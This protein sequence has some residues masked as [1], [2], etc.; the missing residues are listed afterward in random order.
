MSDLLLIFALGFLGSFGHCISMC[1]PLTVAFS[2]TATHQDSASNP[3]LRREPPG[4]Q[5]RWHH[6]RFHLVLNVGRL[7][8]YTLVGMLL[9]MIGAMVV[10]SGQ[11]A[12]VGSDFRRAIAIVTGILLIWFGVR[13]TYPKLLPKI[14]L[15]LIAQT[16]IHHQIDRWMKGLSTGQVS[17]RTWVPAVLG[18]VWGLMP[19]GFLFAAQIKAMSESDPV[20]GALIMLFF[21]LGTLPTMVGIGVTSSLLSQ[22][23]RSQLFRAGGGV[24]IAIGILTLIRTGDLMVDYTAYGGLICLIL[25]LIARPISRLWAAPMRYRR[26]LGVGAFVLSVAHVIHRVEHTWKWNLEALFF[27]PPIYQQ[28]IVIGF[29]GVILLVPLALTSF[30]G[31]QRYLGPRWRMLHLLSIPALVLASIHSVMVGSSFLGSLQLTWLNYTL[32]I[33]LSVSVVGVLL[34]RS[35][36]FWS[37]LSIKQFY[38]LPHSASTQSSSGS[39]SYHDSRDGISSMEAGTARSSSSD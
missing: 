36:W 20:M 32:A 33:L 37:L 6:L 15:S 28:G 17:Q 10:W 23:H 4:K 39:T 29:V 9:G 5:S 3:L 7:L 25:V 35:P 8:T 19:C 12:G 14:P 31:A 26:A 2:L 18:M 38:A 16:Q 24:A 21:G 34:V 11:L 22:N 30:D 27:M 1:G 13:Q